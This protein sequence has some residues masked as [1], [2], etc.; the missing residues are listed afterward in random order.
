MKL[1]AAGYS[2]RRYCEMPHDEKA[3]WVIATIAC[4]NSFNGIAHGGMQIPLPTPTKLHASVIGPIKLV[5]CLDDLGGQS[6][7]R[8]KPHVIR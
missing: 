4:R 7:N 8:A 3:S 1:N 2:V 6:M 5:V